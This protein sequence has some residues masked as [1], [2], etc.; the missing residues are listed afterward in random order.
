MSDD[1]DRSFFH[2]SVNGTSIINYDDGDDDRSLIHKFVHGNS[3][4]KYDNED[5]MFLSQI[6][7]RGFDYTI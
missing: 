2:G 3:V 1:V 6:C 4:M 7:E 5:D